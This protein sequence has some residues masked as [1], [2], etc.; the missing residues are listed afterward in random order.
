V[1]TATLDVTPAGARV[2]AIPAPHVATWVDGGAATG[3]DVSTSDE[4]WLAVTSRGPSSF[5][6]DVLVVEFGLVKHVVTHISGAGPLAL[7]AM[8]TPE[9]LVLERPGRTTDRSYGFSQDG[10][11]MTYHDTSGTSWQGIFQ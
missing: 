11:D 8:V 4:G 1:S 5:Q 3:V 9:G 2:V 6:V 7:G 10:G